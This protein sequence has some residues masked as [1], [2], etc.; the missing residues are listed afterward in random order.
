MT[1]WYLR[2]CRRSN[3]SVRFRKNGVHAISAEGGAEFYGDNQIERYSEEFFLENREL[4]TVF[5]KISKSCGPTFD[6][7]FPVLR[8]KDHKK[9]L[10]ESYVQY[11]PKELTNYIRGF[12]FRYSDIT[13]EG[14]ILLMDILVDARDVYSQRNFDVGTTRQKFHVT[15]KPNVERK[16]RR[17]SKVPLRLKIGKA[18]NTTERRRYLSWNGWRRRNGITIC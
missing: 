7:Q 4:E 10:I 17:P 8:E 2:Q 1:T 5:T 15:L 14:M 9:R 12:D 3:G 13:D 18:T 11:Q 16:K 6:E